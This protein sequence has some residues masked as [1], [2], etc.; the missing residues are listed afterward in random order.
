MHKYPG[1][2]GRQVTGAKGFTLVEL[3][4]AIAIIGLLVMLSY[5]LYT[6]YLDKARAAIAINDL[7]QISK[8][9][10]LYHSVNST[11]PDSLAEVYMSGLLDPWGNPYQYL[12]IASVKGKGKLRKDRNLV[13]INSD[14]DLYSKGPDGESVGPLTAKKSR[15]DVIRAGNGTFYGLAEDF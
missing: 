6:R 9:I 5:P 10:T 8:A 7:S 1:N 15:D 3:M 2:P 4:I 11:Y 12:N 14:Y 13:P